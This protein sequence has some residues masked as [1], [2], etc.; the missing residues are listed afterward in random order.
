MNRKLE[1]LY[2]PVI[3]IDNEGA[4]I[5]TITMKQVINNAFD[6][7]IKIA[8][9]ANP[10]TQLPGNMV[11]G[12]W[13]EELLHNNTY[14]ILYCDLD[15][16]K[17][18][19]DTYGFTK[20]DELLKN[21]ARLLT[22]FFKNI[23]NIKIGHIG[24]DDFIIVSEKTITA[25]KTGELCSLFD[26]MRSAFFSEAH[27]KQ[28][29]YY[30]VNRQEELKAIPLITMSIAVLTEKNFNGIPHPGQLGQVAAGLK[31]QVK[32]KNKEEGGS[33]CLFERRQYNVTNGVPVPA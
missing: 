7:E 16:F 17:E 29:F 13:L 15:H 25:K 26:E 18:Y 8:T 31:R 21:M 12:F 27:I 33:N 30:A 24:G 5:G 4:L 10:L 3:V 23:P 11:I 19:N 32:I 28:G 22:D 14:S 20:G 9:C 2:D 6:L 1:N